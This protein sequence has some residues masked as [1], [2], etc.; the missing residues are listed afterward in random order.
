[1]PNP[2]DLSSRDVNER[3]TWPRNLPTDELI[4]LPFLDTT[5]DEEAA[6]QELRERGYSDRTVEILRAIARP[7]LWFQVV[8]WE[9]GSLGI[10]DVLLGYAVLLLP[11]ALMVAIAGFYLTA[12]FVAAVALLFLGA[13]IA[14][15]I[16]RRHRDY[17]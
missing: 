12:G 4:C 15:F 7:G 2:P 13:S 14:G 11:A 17:R 8:A 16:Y 3:R 5:G 1:M 10:F 9:W 6:A